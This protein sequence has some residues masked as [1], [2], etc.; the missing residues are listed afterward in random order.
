[1]AIDVLPDINEQDY[2]QWQADEF[3]NRARRRSSALNFETATNQ[4]LADLNAQ[5]A[6]PP[7]AAAP[8]P[9][10][11]EPSQPAAPSVTPPADVLNAPDWYQAPSGPTP[12]AD[13]TTPPDWY[14]VQAATPP[15]GPTPPAD[16]LTPPDWFTPPTPSD[17]LVNPLATRGF[18]QPISPQGFTP[19][20]AELSGG[21][22]AAARMS[23]RARQIMAS[24]A[25]SAAWLGPDGQKA[26]QAILVTEG[27]LEGARGDQGASAGPLQFY[28]T[29]TN[30]GQLTNFARQRGMTLE[31][32]R[33]YVE[34]HPEEA[35]AWAIGTPDQPGYLGA[36]L[37]AGQ[38]QGLSGA[39]LATYGQRRGQVSVSPDRAGANYNT[40]FGGGA[41]PV[42]AVAATTQPTTALGQRN[43]EL[44]PPPTDISQFGDPQL[45]NDEA[46]AACGPAAAVRFAQRYGRNPTLREA[47]DLAKTVNWTP[48][49]GMA[50]IASEKALMDKLGVSTRIVEGPQWD[51]FANE[52]QTGNPV[53]ISTRGHYFF[54]DGYDPTTRRF[55]VGRSG[56]DLKGGAEWMTAQQMT[57]LMGPVQG[58]LFADNPQVPALSTAD[59][60]TNPIE[61]LGRQKDALI[62][63]V[64]GD[65]TQP[66]PQPAPEPRQPAR[67]RPSAIDPDVRQLDQAV[68]QATQ[69]PSPQPVPSRQRPSA[70]EQLNQV[71]APSP[72]QPGLL[73]PGNI[74]LTTRPVVRNADGSISTVRS[75]SVGTDDGEVLIPTVSDDGRILSNQEAIDQYR[76]TGKHLGVFSS[77]ETAT[78][79]AQ[80]LHQQ[81]ADQ[82]AP[83]PA[84]AAPPPPPD[85]SPGDRLKSAFSDF[86]DQ[87]GG[88]AGQVG[89]A[90]GGAVS[91]I[92]PPD[93]G[94]LVAAPGGALPPSAQPTPSDVLTRPTLR[95]GEAAQPPPSPPPA[96]PTVFE[97]LPE[98]IGEA[99]PTFA[100]TL[101]PTSA[102]ARQARGEQ[103]TGLAEAALQPFAVADEAS[104]GLARSLLPNAPPEV[105]R[106]LGGALNPANLV[107]GGRGIIGG[108]GAVVGGDAA[109]EI[110]RQAGGDETAQAIAQFVGGLAGGSLA[111]VAAPAVARAG[112]QA[113]AAPAVQ[114]FVTEEEGALFPGRPT[115]P[116]P[117]TGAGGAGMPGPLERTLE[118]FE[119]NDKQPPKLQQVADAGSKFFG[120]RG[121]TGTIDKAMADRMAAINQV[122]G[123]AR[124][125]LGNRFTPEMDAEAYAAV[126]PGRFG[127]A[128]WRVKQDLQPAVDLVGNDLPYLNAYRK[129]QRDAEVA[130][131]R[132]GTRQASAGVTSAA[133][134]QQG[135]NQIE[136]TVGPQRFGNIVKA[137]Q[138]VNDGLNRL[139][140]DRVANGLVSQDLANALKRQHPHY[141]PT[142]ILKYLD[143][144]ARIAGSGKRMMTLSNQVRR[145]AEE[146][147]ADNT[148]A[149][150]RSA[151]RL[152]LSA[153]LRMMQNDV[154]KSTIA[155]AMADPQTAPLIKR[156]PMSQVRTGPE[157]KAIG[158]PPELHDVATIAMRRPVADIPGTIAVWENG[159]P[160]LYQVPPE[161]EEAI[162][163]LGAEQITTVGRVLQALNA[164]LRA[165]ATFASAP[166]TVTNM[167]ADAITTFIREGVGTTARIP[168]GWW[169]AARKDAVFQDYARA[170]GLMESFAQRQ[171]RDLDRLIRDQGGIVPRNYRDVP[172]L[173]ADALENVG[174]L[175]RINEVI[176]QGPH[177]AAYQQGLREGLSPAQAAMRGRRV[178]VDFSRGGNAAKS[179]SNLMLFLNARVQ[180]GLNL[181]RS[182]RDTPAARARLAGLAAATAGLYAWNR[183]FS[184]EYA[185]IP[186][187]IRDQYAVMM[188]PGSERNPNGVGF[189][190]LNYIALPLREIATFTAPITYGLA[191]LD[192]Q[193]PRGVDEFAKSMLRTASPLSGDE[194]G[195]VVGSLLPAPLRTPLEL[196][197]NTRFYSG[198]PIESQAMENLPPTQRFNERTSNLARGLSEKVGM[199]SPMQWDFVIRE[200]LGG[201]GMQIAA[202]NDLAT[203]RAPDTPPVIGGLLSGVWR[204]Q[205]GATQQR[206]YE[207]LDRLMSTYQEPIAAAVRGLPEFQSATPDRQQQMLRSAQLGLRQTLSDQLGIQPPTSDTGLGP[208]YQGVDDP[209]QERKIEAAITKVD[210]WHQNTKNPMPTDEEF[211]LW[212]RYRMPGATNL[213]YRLGR[214]GQQGEAA[215]IRNLIQQNVPAYTGGR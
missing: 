5:Y 128:L 38:N 55:H 132:G 180:G 141:N 31:Q 142:V 209:K 186:D 43:V 26:L 198:T 158:G 178:T 87:I 80:Q 134:A 59:Q 6:P 112:R 82:Y 33:A 84:A 85:Q 18:T 127:S 100:P 182:L 1:M 37:Q 8:E 75:I 211:A 64:T 73:E 48:Q 22:P 7:Q 138:I 123:R 152:M 66:T 126:F 65:Q 17:V 147:A 194:L 160:Q 99:L 149:P 162:K 210:R 192:Q 193:D 183:Q 177:L 71:Y 110:V 91:S 108:A 124:A 107:F 205:G 20:T 165:G 29:A 67:Q 206:Q 13:V 42:T 131:L 170:G 79:Y 187:Y 156:I 74:D 109:R 51:A 143:D 86:I 139:L 35:I 4:Q 97:Q 76:R 176:E 200:N 171:P 119:Q 44:A 215:D 24:A 102:I 169:R 83:S 130:N 30:A 117:P 68:D 47:V 144:E 184:E 105:Q 140:D 81:Q 214:I 62:S 121:E 61:W 103:P 3:S 157:V 36:A 204:R 154:A 52:A 159:K 41:E 129:F 174:P 50:G 179:A 106:A 146:G 46:Y 172:R 78:A 10:T 53:T 23:D 77:P 49:Q 145:L 212:S 12:P 69:Q 39:A 98:R 150:M 203:G 202:A 27:G 94:E 115:P 56:L 191:K 137:D 95:T 63:A 57:N 14:Q 189:K 15:S 122:T 72:A 54:A 173:I 163:G 118:M 136:A 135:I 213:Q 19:T 40:L 155:A 175:R 28:G 114:R 92:R 45:T 58:A 25:S 70:L 168:E 151:T 161:I 153:Q 201:L 188:L 34:Q 93:V 88:A 190:K 9:A 166:F 101:E 207:Q 96:Q 199:L 16:V 196:M 148:E 120:L 113:L 197:T 195:S 185:D 111:D 164:P 89:G 116:T 125:A 32:A 133:E 90:I 181:G 11:P 21:G 167:I 2:V 208:K 104:Q 60:A